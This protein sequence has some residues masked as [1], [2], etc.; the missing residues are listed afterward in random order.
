PSITLEQ[1]GFEST[2][3]VE[4]EAGAEEEN[5]RPRKRLGE[6]FVADGLLKAS[7]V[8]RALEVQA[9]SKEY[10]RLGD[11]LVEMSLVSV[12]QVRE[13]LSRQVAD[14]RRRLERSPADALGWVEL[15]NL[16]LDVSD[17]YGAVEAYLKA[18]EIYRATGREKMVF[19]LLEG[20]LDICPESLAAAR[21]LV[22]IRSSLGPQGQARSLYRLAVAY[23]LNDSPH[24][25]VAALEASVQADPGFSMATALL[26]GVRPGVA[27]DMENY[28][29]IASI[30]ADIDRMFD[31]DSAR[32]LAGLV[33]EFQEGVRDAVSPDDHQ[34]HYDLGI[35]YREMGLLREAIAEFNQVL[36]SPEHRLRAREMLG[37]CYHDMGRYDEAE[38]QFQ[39]GLSIAGK[40]GT[41]QVGFHLNLARVYEVTGRKRQAEAERKAASRIDPVL[42]TIQ[43]HLE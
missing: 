13:A 11:V 32:A 10:R 38:E 26:E 1:V 15:G 19:E 17:F 41:S 33:K 34:T 31:Q 9:S 14:M 35:A 6:Y 21:E 24:E 42:A 36:Q 39:K 29:D 16:L 43:D 28:A 8:L 5:Q 22:R 37:R 18:A 12:R 25:A 2:D 40:D 27:A 7:D 30:L 20:V 4:E 23:L 3:F